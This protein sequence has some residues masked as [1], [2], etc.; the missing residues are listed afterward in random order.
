MKKT[1]DDANAYYQ[2]LSEEDKRIFAETVDFKVA[3]NKEMM[4]QMF[5]DEKEARADAMLDT[6]AETHDLDAGVLKA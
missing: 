2:Q 3:T 6:A 5:L 4:E 1:V